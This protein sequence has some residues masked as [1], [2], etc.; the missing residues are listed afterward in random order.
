MLGHNHNRFFPLDPLVSCKNLSCIG[1]QCGADEAKIICG[2]EE[3]EDNTN[4]VVYSIGG[5]NQWKFELDILSRTRSN[6]HTFDCTGDFARFHK[7]DHGRIHFHHICLSDKY[8]APNL[9]CDKSRGVCGAMMTLKEIQI[10]LNHSRIDFLKMDIEG[11]EWP[12]FESWYAMSA[13]MGAPNE[14]WVLPMQIAAEIHYR[15][16][17]V[18]EDLFRSVNVTPS[19][20]AEFR[21]PRDMVLLEEKMLR[22]G[23]IPIYNDLNVHCLHCTEVTWVRNAQC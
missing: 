3:L 23:Y 1:G 5:N 8:V 10:M 4:C 2:L 13:E 14:K 18:F 12:V 19:V 15:T 6:V 11:Y 9:T 20:G 17:V 7:P 21:S 16:Y 22:M